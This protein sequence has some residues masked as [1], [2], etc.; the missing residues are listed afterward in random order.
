ML[1][2][3]PVKLDTYIGEPIYLKQGE[4]ARD[5]A[6]RVRESLQSLI[7]SSNALPERK[8]KRKRK[9]LISFVGATAFGT[10]MLLQN[11]GFVALCGAWTALVAMPIFMINGV[12]LR[13]KLQSV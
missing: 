1:F 3:R 11:V 6:A 2:P 7:H 13:N 10:F 12:L 5:L 8:F 4:S 9:G